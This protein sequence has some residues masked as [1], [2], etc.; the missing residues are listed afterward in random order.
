MSGQV[1]IEYFIP[2]KY[3]VLKNL[4][5]YYPQ[6]ATSYSIEW[7]DMALVFSSWQSAAMVV[8]L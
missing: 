7:R 1:P 3:H 5:V 6:S 4:D 8:R 2:I